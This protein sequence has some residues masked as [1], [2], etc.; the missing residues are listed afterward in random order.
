[1]MLKHFFTLQG[2]F[3]VKKCNKKD[4]TASLEAETFSCKDENRE[5]AKMNLRGKH[6]PEF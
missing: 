5:A 3:G 4:L 2:L 6:Q 1:M